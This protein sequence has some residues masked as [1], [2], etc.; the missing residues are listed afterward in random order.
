[1]NYKYDPWDKYGPK[2]TWPNPHQNKDYK[3]PPAPKPVTID[4]LFPN[5]D[6]FTIGWGSLLDD[7]QTVTKT[8]TSYPPYDIVELED[9]KYVVNVAIAGFRREDIII[10]SEDSTLSVTGSYGLKE[11]GAKDAVEEKFIHNGIARRD[12]NLNFMLAEHVEVEYAKLE[13][14]V[15]SIHLFKNVPEEKLPKVIDIQ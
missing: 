13:D 10:T 8:R 5:L 3:T 6:R 11:E 4:A 9:N 1:M 15:L 2:D 7:L 12:F 14:G